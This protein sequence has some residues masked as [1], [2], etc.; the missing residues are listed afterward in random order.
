MDGIRVGF[1]SSYDADTGT[2][3]IYY[4]DRCHEVTDNLPV[5]SPFGLLQTLKK[6]DAVIV[7]HLSNGQEAG[8]VIGTYSS[9]GDVPAAGF[10]IEGGRLIF[11]DATGSISLKEIITKCRE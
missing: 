7:L 5:F 9:D 6:G 4:P 8:I 10:T 1:V 11:K 3:A 2:A